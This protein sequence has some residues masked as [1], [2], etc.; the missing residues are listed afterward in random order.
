MSKL[1]A[2]QATLETHSVDLLIF[3]KKWCKEND[4]MRIEVFEEENAVGLELSCI[5]P[6]NVYYKDIEHLPPS[7]TN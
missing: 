4:V 5:V 7:V 3:L 2:Y 1:N 6:N